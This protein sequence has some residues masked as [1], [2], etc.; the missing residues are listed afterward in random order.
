MKKEMYNDVFHDLS[1]E[2]VFHDCCLKVL[3]K[4]PKYQVNW[5][6]GFFD[7]FKN[8]DTRDVPRRPFYDHTGKQQPEAESV[9]MKRVISHFVVIDNDNKTGYSHS[10]VC[11]KCY[12]RILRSDHYCSYCGQKL[13]EEVKEDN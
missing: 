9:K 6:D 1:N 11:G 13:I 7:E 5:Y 4:K 3:D 10:Y 12:T 2:D 8:V